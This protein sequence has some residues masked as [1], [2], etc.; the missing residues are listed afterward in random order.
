MIHF[1]THARHG[2]DL[3]KALATGTST[4]RQ[5]KQLERWAKGLFFAPNGM[6][7]C[8][9]RPKTMLFRSHFDSLAEYQ[10]L[11]MPLQRVLGAAKA[12][13]VHICEELITFSLYR[14]NVVLTLYI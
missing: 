8:Q 9:K 13:L 2:T 14:V 6:E 11:P 7:I 12:V 5:L 4:L 3:E 1:R 10:H